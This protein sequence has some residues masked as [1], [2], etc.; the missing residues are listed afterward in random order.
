MERKPDE[1]GANVYKIKYYATL[2]KNNELQ[3]Q[4]AELNFKLIEYSKLLEQNAKLNLNSTI[5]ASPSPTTAA[6]RRH[7]LHLQQHF[8]SSGLP[9]VAATAPSAPD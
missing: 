7:L 1:L 2:T 5:T 4:H 3:G 8:C 6:Q 9:D